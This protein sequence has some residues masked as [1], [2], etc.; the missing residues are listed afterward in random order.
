MSGGKL[1]VV[2]DGDKPV[3]IMPNSNTPI[4]STHN[5]VI[6][7]EISID[8]TLDNDNEVENIEQND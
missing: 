4:E 7:P 3:V 6:N 8:T 2:L 1:I 5:Q